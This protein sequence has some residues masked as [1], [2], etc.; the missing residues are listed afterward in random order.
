VATANRFYTYLLFVFAGYF[1]LVISRLSGSSM[2]FLSDTG[3]GLLAGTNRPIRSDEYLRGTPTE[4]GAIN[5]P[6]SPG[7]SLLSSPGFDEPGIEEFELLRPERFFIH[8]LLGGEFAYSAIWWMPAL[9]V[10]IGV[11]LLLKQFKLPLSISVGLSLIIILS[12]SV[13]WWSNGMAGIIGRL[14]LGVALIIMASRASGLKIWVLGILGSWV[15]SGV[16]MDYQPWSII[17]SLFFLPLVLFFVFQQKSKILPLIGAGLFGLAPLVY[18]LFGKI[19]IFQVMSETLYP[20]QRRVSS[21][22]INALNWSLVAPQQWSLLNPDGINYSNQSEISMGFFLFVFPALYFAY[23]SN[24]M[25]RSF[26]IREVV[27]GGYLIVTSWAFIQFPELPF[28]PLS[29]VSPERTLTMVTTL[30]PLVF[31]LLYANWRNEQQTNSVDVDSGK[32]PVIDYWANAALA[33]L[34]VALTF[35]AAMTMEGVV[36]NFSTRLAVVV[37]IVCG[38][39]VYLIIHPRFTTL[40]V[41][42][43]VLIAVFVGG[44]VN[45]VAQGTAP[46]TDNSLSQTLNSIKGEGSWAADGIHLDAMLIANGKPSISGQQLTGPDRSKWTLI[47]PQLVN[48][49]IWNAGAS[50]V[51]FAWDSSL[52]SP[53]LTR[54]FGDTI[55]VRINPCSE[56]LNQLD[57]RFIVSR[58]ELAAPCILANAAETVQWLGGPVYI[59]ELNR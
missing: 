46:L 6:D 34:V 51:V 40:G 32:R 33:V 39:F 21:G 19:D 10:L 55:L 25:R 16:A 9:L 35:S 45:P 12:P 13:V 56:S 52:E 59:Y 29:L 7:V 49:G 41:W 2:G 50:F 57:L 28:N 22:L 11:P 30:A 23:S 48:E 42:G 36:L 1:D 47:D 31:G 3:Q 4:I 17:G 44:A 27:L 26:G 15:A 14:S 58:S 8:I 53:E 43:F 54:P 24:L 5:H 37:S 38:I 20:G 18:F